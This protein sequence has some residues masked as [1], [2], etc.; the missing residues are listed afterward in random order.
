M[1]KA[2]VQGLGG[3]TLNDQI[4]KGGGISTGSV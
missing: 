4:S 3:K 1:A 2:D